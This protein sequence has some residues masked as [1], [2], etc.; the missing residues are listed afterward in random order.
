LE[1]KRG[2]CKLAATSFEVLTNNQ[3]SMVEKRDTTAPIKHGKTIVL[4]AIL[5][6]GNL[7]AAYKSSHPNKEKNGIRF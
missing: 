3:A 6:S 5:L 1:I 4:K 2:T 7:M